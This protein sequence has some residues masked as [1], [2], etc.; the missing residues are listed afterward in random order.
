MAW[1]HA[2][3]GFRPWIPESLRGEIDGRTLEREASYVVVEEI[4]LDRARTVVS[5][6]PMLDS[7]GRMHFGDPEDADEYVDLLIDIERLLMERRPVPVDDLKDRPA[8]VGDVFAVISPLGGGGP[9]PGNG[10]PRGGGPGGGGPGAGG[11]SVARLTVALE[12][13]SSAEIYD[14]TADARAAATATYS[15]ATAGALSEEDAE[16]FFDDG[17]DETTDEG[18]TPTP[19]PSGD[20]PG[21]GGDAM[22]SETESLVSVVAQQE[23]P[24]ETA[25]QV[26]TAT[27]GA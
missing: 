24:A 4:L 2:Q 17:E 27:A 8:E 23:L 9:G 26:A 5:T 18:G 19:A 6:W 7:D 22:P 21:A 13:V 3:E 20:W 16:R 15:S 25:Q 12:A 10:G 14:I 11:D 1:A